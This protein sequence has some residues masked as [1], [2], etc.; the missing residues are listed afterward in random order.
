MHET[1][2]DQIRAR[3]RAMT[4]SRASGPTL[5][6]CLLG[7]GSNE[8]GTKTHWRI[9]PGPSLVE[10]VTLRADTDPADFEQLQIL[11]EA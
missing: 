9:G 5:G 7:W 10:G 4:C 2:R 11:L 8:D 6:A 1:R 3:L